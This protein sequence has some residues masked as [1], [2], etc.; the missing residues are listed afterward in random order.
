VISTGYSLNYFQSVFVASLLALT[1]SLSAS[2]DGVR[3][4]GYPKEGRLEADGSGHYGDLVRSILAEANY[5]ASFTTA[6]VLRSLRELETSSHTCVFPSSVEALAE[7]GLVD[8][9]ELLL[10]SAPIDYVTGHIV[11][12]PGS[13]MISDVSQ[14]HGKAIAAWR[15]VNVQPYLGDA[16][17][18][19]L[20]TDNE[21]NAIRLL[22]TGRVD[23]IWNWIP[24]AY[25][26]FERLEI[27]PPNLNAAKAFY[28]SEIQFVCS[29]DASSEA[30]LAKIDPVIEKMRSQGRLKEILGQYSR[31][32]G[33]DAQPVVQKK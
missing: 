26:L 4:V 32:V 30:F 31:I 33:V 12:L 18:N 13:E 25:I 20:Q 23:A 8:R 14:L 16:S 24:D 17:V 28:A 15:G 1:A 11:T 3:I 7:Q 27:G 5:D 2:A 21:F 10:G 19:V 22:Q 6:P 29:P 9:A